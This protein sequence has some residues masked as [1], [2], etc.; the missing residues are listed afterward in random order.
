[1]KKL[2]LRNNIINIPADALVYSTNVQLMMSGGVGGTLLQLLGSQIQA[3]LRNALDNSA[4][5]NVG[6][7]FLSPL[8]DEKW[9]V[10]Y[11]CVAADPMYHTEPA[12]IECLLRKVLQDADKRGFKS[13]LMSALG[14]GYGDLESSDFLL[15]LDKVLQLEN[16]SKIQTITICTESESSFEDLRIAARNLNSSWVFE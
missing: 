10:I 9:Q 15:L 11:H 14:T 3:E 16:L 7:L 13:I 8:T 1:M 5:A 4:L 6:D 2:I 12:I